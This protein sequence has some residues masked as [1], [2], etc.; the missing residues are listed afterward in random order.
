M[1]ERERRRFE[2]GELDALFT[3]IFKSLSII[4]N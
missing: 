1:V 3:W 2:T 4:M